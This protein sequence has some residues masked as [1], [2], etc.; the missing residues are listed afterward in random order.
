[1]GKKE[2]KLA[3]ASSDV[4]YDQRGFGWET[5]SRRPFDPEQ[6]PQ[7]RHGNNSTN[8]VLAQMGSDL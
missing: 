2:R 3:V 4:V 1:M 8:R 5:Q 7:Y 6:S